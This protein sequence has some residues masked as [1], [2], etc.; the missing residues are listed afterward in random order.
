MDAHPAADIDAR[1]S[2]LST[3]VVDAEARLATLRHNIVQLKAHRNAYMSY[4]LRLPK[5][6]LVHIASLCALDSINKY[7]IKR[8]QT[9]VSICHTLRTLFVRT[10]EL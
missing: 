4:I 6:I 1:I 3:E 9:F 10:P 7:A 5:E 8:I 2:A